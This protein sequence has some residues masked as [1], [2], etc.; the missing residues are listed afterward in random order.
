MTRCFTLAVLGALVFGS[1]ATHADTPYPSKT[2]TLVV[3]YP[4]GGAADAFARPFAQALAKR[5]GQAVVIDNRSGANGNIGSVY[6]AKTQPADGY[7]LLLGST[8]TL[9]INPHIYKFM[10]YDPLKD[11]QPLTLTHRMPNVLVAGTGTPYQSVGDVIAAAKAKPDELVFGSA[12]NGNTM[13]LAGELFQIRGGIKML[14]AP[15]KGGAP[16]L[17]DVL[18]GQIPM[19]FN[20]LPAIVPFVKAGKLR[21]LAVADN[22]RSPLL[23]DVPTMAEAGLPNASSVVWNGILVRKGTPAAIAERLEKEMKAVLNTAE[24]RKPLEAQGYEVLSSTPSEFEALMLKDF[25]SMG[26][27][28]KRAGIQME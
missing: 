21:A 17:N 25:Q 26:Q 15:Y 5:L 13:H 28:I 14:H 27:L 8:S 11:L 22:Q 18:A 10:G 20:N 3:P 1:A 2:V 4:A 24:F 12:G 16:A 6:V 19:M 23:P 9:T 7:A